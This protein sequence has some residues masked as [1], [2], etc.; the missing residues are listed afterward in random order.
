[1]KILPDYI[2]E[3]MPDLEE[4]IEELRLSVLDHAYDLLKCLDVDELSSDDIRH[5]LELYD[6]KVENMSEAWLPNNR[7]YRMYPEI[8]HNRT[9]YN[10][11]KSIVHSGG[12]F[13]G[14]WSTGFSNKSEYNFRN[15]QILRHYSLGSDLDGYFYVSGNPSLAHGATSSSALQ[16]L[17]TDILMNQALPAGYTYLYVPWPRPSYPGDATYYYNVHMLD[18]DR[19]YYDA[20]FGCADREPSLMHYD[21]Q[22][23][24]TK[25]NW[26]EGS[27]TPL[28]TPYWFDYHYLNPYDHEK[29]PL[30]ERGKYIE[31][32]GDDESEIAN[33]EDKYINDNSLDGTKY[34]LDG[35]C[36]ELN[37]STN[38]YPTRC[39][40]YYKFRNLAPSR[41][42][43]FTPKEIDDSVI[44]IDENYTSIDDTSKPS[45]AHKF[46]YLSK[47]FPI[48]RRESVGNFGEFR[49]MWNENTLF[50]EMAKSDYGSEINP[51]TPKPNSL[52]Y[53][54][55]LK[56]QNNVPIF[57]DSYDDK[58]SLFE[59]SVNGGP[60]C[61]NNIATVT[62]TNYD[63]PTSGRL[64]PIYVAYTQPAS[65]GQQGNN[66]D[67]FPHIL[68]NFGESTALQNDREYFCRPIKYG[69]IDEQGNQVVQ[70][71]EEFSAAMPTQ[72]SSTDNMIIQFS[73]NID[74]P[75]N[76]VEYIKTKVFRFKIKSD[77]MA[78]LSDS[79][80]PVTWLKDDEYA[81]Y[82]DVLELHDE[83]GN[84]I[85]DKSS[86]VVIKYIDLDR[87]NKAC[88]LVSDH[89]GE[90]RLAIAVYRETVVGIGM[91]ELFNLL[92]GETVIGL[93]RSSDNSVSLDDETWID[94]STSNLM[95]IENRED[96][97][98]GSTQHTLYTNDD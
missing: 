36:A 74:R 13:E 18:H 14:V 50:A 80:S 25:Y 77:G 43:T 47:H 98:Y 67:I 34:V 15:I 9:R 2:I 51:S 1:M 29:W 97:Y 76:Y 92:T 55:E 88:K 95:I 70:R 3:Y 69:Y 26:I 41:L 11:I 58:Y 53:W 82:Y 66:R 32:S 30:E 59:D 86:K 6:I 22:P 81:I 40:R 8:R 4:A 23:A 10:A 65:S 38:H 78:L 54:S 90:A 73:S 89:V 63:R 28:R 96:F 37:H 46:D 42:Q 87:T 60:C 21:A 94:Y 62:A 56:R 48:Y 57:S 12:Q 91:V 93:Y 19:L 33:I 64:S 79:L 68:Y 20:S 35:G 83:L 17:Q 85:D 27:G 84:I 44:T 7:F 39:Y 5:K 52:Y 24:S 61:T 49:P 72:S 31:V 45:G 71:I 75:V 16:A